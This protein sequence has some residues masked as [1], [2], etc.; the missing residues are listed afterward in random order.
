M[1][2]QTY[3]KLIDD[4]K[5]AK[6]LQ[7]INF[8]G[9]G[10][11]LLHPDLAEMVAQAKKL[12]VKTQII[13]NAML[14]DRAKAE[15]LVVA[16]LDSIVV[17]IDGTNA[18]TNSDIRSGADLGLVVNQIKQLRDFKQQS[19]KRNPEIGLEYVLMKKNIHELEYLRRLAFDVGASFIVI[20]NLLPY[21]SEMKDEILYNLSLGNIFKTSRSK[22]APEIFIPPLDFHA[23]IVRH[24]SALVGHAGYSSTVKPQI[25]NSHGYCRFVAEGSAVVAWDGEVSPCVA[26]MHSYNCFILGREKKI[27]RYTI[28]N[29]NQDNINHLMDKEEFNNFR[30][31]VQLFDFS[32]CTD[33]GGCD[34]AET[35]EEDCFGNTFPVCGDCL[36]AKGVI[37]CP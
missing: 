11:P 17:S 28:G 13:T 24:L 10:E 26:L 30:D 5:E 27:K 25:N 2:L 4:L 14:L 21:N 12:N 19:G 1:K 7:Q 33:C 34:L 16:G 31:R 6:S 3:N 32:P 15:Q 23:D 36:W 8:W 18:T 9:F 29:V 22:W 35:N 37:Q 20:T